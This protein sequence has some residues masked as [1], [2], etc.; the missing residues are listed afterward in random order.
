MYSPYL[1]PTEYL[2][3]VSGGI[4]TSI[5]IRL[6]VFL[7]LLTGIVFFSIA[8]VSAEKAAVI[9]SDTTA[10]AGIGLNTDSTLI[11]AGDLPDGIVNS[12]EEGTAV[13][14]T[15]YS[16][17]AVQSLLA[18]RNALM[19]ATGEAFLYLLTGTST[20]K[21][22]CIDEMN[23]VKDYTAAFVEEYDLSAG[24][25]GKGEDRF[26]ELLTTS[27]AMISAADTMFASYEAGTTEKKEIADFREQE[28]SVSDTIDAL[29]HDAK[30]PGLYQGNPDEYN[31]WLIGILLDAAGKTYAYPVTG[32]IKEK[33]EALALFTA[34]DSRL[35]EAEKQFPDASFEDLKAGKRNL[36]IAAKAIYASYEADSYV[37]Q[38]ELSDL[39]TVLEGITDSP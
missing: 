38:E 17:K 18:A 14:V 19:T 23:F 26:H 10:D 16:Q 29:C 35:K 15:A 36:L 5:M 22:Q 12:T 39:K 25:T 4:D 13:S 33:K 11:L 37:Y 28:E 6:P 30:I 7:I 20:D 31:Q 32:D 9:I 21:Q 8:T 2:F 3:L 1:I 24:E 34:F 27:D